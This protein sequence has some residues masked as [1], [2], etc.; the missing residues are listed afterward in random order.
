MRRRHH[1][2]N[3]AAGG[4]V[5][6]VLLPEGAVPVSSG[7][8]H[9]ASV[10]REDQSEVVCGRKEFTEVGVSTAVKGMSNRPSAL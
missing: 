9:V 5:G 7:G 2:S 4:G 6:G 10:L 3:R 8:H 1:R